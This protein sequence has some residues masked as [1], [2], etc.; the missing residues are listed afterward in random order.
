MSIN[1]MQADLD[2]WNHIQDGELNNLR[3]WPE[4]KMA[5]W[6]LSIRLDNLFVDSDEA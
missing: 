2:V 4:I 6:Q 5:D 1:A 3:S